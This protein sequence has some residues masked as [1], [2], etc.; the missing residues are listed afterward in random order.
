MSAGTG[1]SFGT[2]EPEPDYDTIVVGAGLGGLTAGSYLAQRGQSVL[3]CDRNS[4]PGGLAVTTCADGFRLS[5]CPFL[6]WGAYPGGWTSAMLDELGVA[7]D[8]PL[9]PV[10][11]LS[12]VIL[13]GGAFT[14]P[15]D[16]VLFADQL[17]R[18]FPADGPGLREFF[19][20]LDLL[21]DEWQ[22]ISPDLSD[23]PAGSRMDALRDM[24]F[25]DYLDRFISGDGRL[26][27][28][29]SSSWSHWGLPP[30]MVSG[31]LAA[32]LLGFG[33]RGMVTLQGGPSVLSDA[34]AAALQRA[35]GELRLSTT[36]TQII[37]E[38]GR[39][40]GVRLGDGTVVTAKSVISNAPAVHTYMDLVG[41]QFLP[42]S[43]VRRLAAMQP[44]MSA[45]QVYL[46]T[47]LDL[48]AIPGLTAETVVLSDDDQDEV[49]RRAIQGDFESSFTIFSCSLLD[50]TAA[51]SGLHTLKL[52]GAG[53]YKRRWLD[54]SRDKD[55]IATR[56]I[57][58]AELVIPGLSDH[59]VWQEISTPLE[60]AAIT[61]ASGAA[62]Y[63]WSA[64]PSQIGPGRLSR[65]AP[66]D[67]L[68]LAGA[69]TGP[70]AGMDLCMLSGKETAELI[71]R[72]G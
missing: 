4:R 34:L 32:L 65:K 55:A 31:L 14:I 51:P 5:H 27:A 46:G 63:G 70:F 60:L 71:L 19:R 9:L 17:C 35:G 20:E 18:D 48:A 22:L 66:V 47:D 67:G 1:A 13:P 61:N 57:K 28:I 29:L 68:Y 53:P 2:A 42:I 59:I 56:M 62:I 6:L 39:A 21:V 26:R 25:D 37:V 58:A 36:V 11:P 49:F 38:E 33:H 54:W 8:V 64:S 23:I 12:R 50:P 69:W 16:P 3:V 7:S 41:R 72:G 10:D 30:S 40:R 45:F 43:M 15:S 52:L 44:S 24:T